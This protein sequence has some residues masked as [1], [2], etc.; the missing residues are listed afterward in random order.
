MPQKYYTVK[1]LALLCTWPVVKQYSRVKIAV[2][3][4]GSESGLGLSEVDPT[5]ML[6]GI[7]MQIALK[8]GL[9]RVLHAQDFVRSSRNVT[10][11]EINNRRLTW[12]IC[13]IA[14]HK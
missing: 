2:E 5:F 12:T 4:Q 13:N 9:H 6:S 14:A 3:N 10:W 7:M 11:E 8:T 1:A